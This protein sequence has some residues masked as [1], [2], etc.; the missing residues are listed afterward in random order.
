MDEQCFWTENASFG[1]LFKKLSPAVQ[2]WYHISADVVGCWPQP[3]P[4]SSD[5]M[6][7][8]P[9]M[10]VQEASFPLPLKEKG[11]MGDKIS[12]WA[13]HSSGHW[14]LPFLLTWL[15]PL[16]WCHPP[17]RTPLPQQQTPTRMAT[18]V[19]PRPQRRR[20]TTQLWA[21]PS[22]LAGRTWRKCITEIT[23]CLY[24]CYA[25]CSNTNSSPE[26]H[27]RWDPWPSEGQ[28]HC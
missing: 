28:T 16:V 22:R 27:P 15:E 18:E 2:W 25:T 17:P 20:P 19:L 23:E 5:I 12:W 6:T 14:S 7:T 13:L 21:L 4:T 1:P 26:G 24:S 9:R 3:R 8:K 10:E 11:G